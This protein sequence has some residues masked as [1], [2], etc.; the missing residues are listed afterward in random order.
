[1]VYT[2]NMNAEY[3]TSAKNPTIKY[4]KK[5]INSS[6]YRASEQRAV[7][8]GI[9]L[10]QSLLKSN[11]EPKLILYAESALE[12]D[13]IK[14]LVGQIEP[15][16]TRPVV[17]KDSVFM[18]ISDIHTTNGILAVF[19][20]ATVGMPDKLTQNTVLL[21]A[22]QDPGNLGTILRTVAAAGIRDVM[23][24]DDSASAWSPKTLRAG[25]GAQFALNICEDA[26][27]VALVSHAQIPSIAAALDEDSQS[28]YSVN[29][30]TN[31][32]WVFGNEGQGVSD[33]LL[34]ACKTKVIIP[35]ADNTVESLNVA[36]SVAVCLFEQRRQSQVQN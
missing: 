21:E 33:E 6:K 22:I 28:L 31:V 18:T 25:M 23:V 24:S 9:H 29:L 12:N 11:I 36:A 34:A 7:I 27:L 35:Q 16:D 13:E 1:M 10:T 2:T 3:V 20:P 15:S 8:E 32:V 5:L 30:E 17:L 19:E 4:V 26:D 14:E